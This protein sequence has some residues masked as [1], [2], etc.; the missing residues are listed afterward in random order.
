MVNL[1]DVATACGLSVSQ[2]SRALNGRQDVS[3]ETKRR[4]SQTAA[5]MG[6][7]KNLTAQTLSAKKS[8]KL[9][10]VVSGGQRADGEL[11]L[12]LWYYAGSEFVGQSE[13]LR[14]RGIYDGEQPGMLLDVLQAA[15]GG[16]NDPDE[17]G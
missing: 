13:R 10:V 15:G 4:V 14:D 16:M 7:V 5:A 12:F 6:Y 8:M 11:L 2:T 3:E 9:A 17:C 1:V